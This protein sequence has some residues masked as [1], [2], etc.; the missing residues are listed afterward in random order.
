MTSATT[1]GSHPTVELLRKLAGVPQ[2]LA[3]L[4][5]LTLIA[6]AA[7][8]SPWIVPVDAEEMDFDNL[9]SGPERRAL[10]RLR[11]DG[12]RHAGDD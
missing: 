9:L 5:V 4:V 11:P 2:A 7:V 1:T 10:A 12:P 3:G 6:A 8:L